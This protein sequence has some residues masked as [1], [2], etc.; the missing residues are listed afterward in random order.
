MLRHASHVLVSW[1]A[2]RRRLAFAR[3]RRAQNWRASPNKRPR[4]RCAPAVAHWCAADSNPR[5]PRY[6]IST[7][8]RRLRAACAALSPR[9][10]SQLTMRRVAS[11]GAAVHPRRCRTTSRDEPELS[12]LVYY[13]VRVGRGA[14]AM[15]ARHWERWAHLVPARRAGEAAVAA[16]GRLWVGQRSRRG[17]EP[18]QARPSGCAGGMG[19]RA[20]DAEAVGGCAWAAWSDV[21]FARVLQRFSVEA[22]FARPLSQ[23]F[24]D[25]GIVLSW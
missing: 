10:Y 20:G 13:R 4:G 25:E 1:P 22:M 6:A 8:S 24:G 14:S 16:A 21:G 23:N 12:E 15:A 19:K 7:R 2:W 18:A 11:R 17:G 5:E 3:G 9:A